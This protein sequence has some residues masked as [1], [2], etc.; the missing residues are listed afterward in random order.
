MVGSGIT[1][2]PTTPSPPYPKSG[3]MDPFSWYLGARQPTSMSDCFENTQS[4]IPVPRLRDR[5]DCVGRVIT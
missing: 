3:V 2:R 1:H 5:N 4:E